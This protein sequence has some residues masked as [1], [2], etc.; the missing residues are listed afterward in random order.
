MCIDNGKDCG[1]VNAAISNVCIDQAKDCG[2]VNAAVSNVRIGQAKDCG[3]VNAAVSNLCIGQDMYTKDNCKAYAA[4]C[5][6]QYVNV[7]VG[8]R[9]G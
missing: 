1:A 8:A 3:T 4:C 5:S 6:E 7:C 9:D 2:A